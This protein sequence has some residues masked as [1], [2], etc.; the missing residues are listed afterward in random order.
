MRDRRQSATERR[1]C[2]LEH[3]LAAGHMHH[4]HLLAGG[5]GHAFDG[6]RHGQRTTGVE[7]LGLG[8]QQAADEWVSAFDSVL[9]T[10]GWLHDEDLAVVTVMEGNCA[11]INA[12]ILRLSRRRCDDSSRSKTLT[13]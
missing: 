12:A 2:G 10:M 4:A 5:V 13:R 8:W 11:E 7:M 3:D 9:G 6:N 1:W